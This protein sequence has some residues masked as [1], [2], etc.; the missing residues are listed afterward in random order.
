MFSGFVSIDCLISA[1][2]GRRGESG[3]ITHKHTHTHICTRT[4]EGHRKPTRR[5]NDEDFEQKSLLLI[6]LYKYTIARTNQTARGKQK[7][8][9]S[10]PEYTC[11]F[12]CCCARIFPVLLRRRPSVMFLFERSCSFLTYVDFYADARCLTTSTVCRIT[13]L[14]YPVQK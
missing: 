6:P 2:R 3:R 4:H 8:V 13:L 5:T 10:L 12:Y 14:T 11:I 7:I 9:R 1:E